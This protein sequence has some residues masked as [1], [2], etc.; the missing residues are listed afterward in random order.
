MIKTFILQQH[1]ASDHG[2]CRIL[3]V[4][5]FTYMESRFSWKA[6]FKDGVIFDILFTLFVFCDN[7]CFSPKHDGSFF[8]MRLKLQMYTMKSGLSFVQ[9]LTILIKHLIH[10]Q[11]LHVTKHEH[12]MKNCFNFYCR[13]L[14]LKITAICLQTNVSIL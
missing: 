8:Q 13:V 4:A 9:E 3:V 2:K 11:Q 14:R 1:F 12:F 6:D 7:S 10:F 5:W